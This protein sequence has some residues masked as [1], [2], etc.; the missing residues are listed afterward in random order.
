MRDTI[1]KETAAV[2]SAED[3]S[4]SPT[5][6]ELPLVMAE[7]VG[8]APP[9]KKKKKK[10]K[11][12][13]IIIPLVILLFVG[14]GLWFYTHR[15]S[16]KD[17]AGEVLSDTVQRG[18]ITSMVEGNGMTKAKNSASIAIATAGTV[19]DV[20]VSEGTVVSAGAPLFLINSPTAQDAVKKAQ[21]DVD[22][23]AKQLKT[24]YEAN[25]NLTVTVPHNGKLMEVADTQAG[26]TVSAEQVLAKVVDDSSMKLEQYYSYAYES[27]IY[28]GQTVNVSI[29]S[30]MQTLTGTITAVKKIRVSLRKALSFFVR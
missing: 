6:E 21:K 4:A 3:T 7:I 17:A 26:N 30:I 5:Q 28:V 24:L 11:K 18:S 19:Q 25:A 14:G 9:I 22:G 8:A 1:D 2:P 10:F 16:G 23:Y 15:P 27:N 12:K 29:P 20:Y 13:L